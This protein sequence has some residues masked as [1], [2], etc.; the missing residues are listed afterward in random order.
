MILRF[1]I[2]HNHCTKCKTV[3]CNL[4]QNCGSSRGRSS[5]FHDG[6]IPWC[7]LG[8]WLFLRPRTSQTL[9]NHLLTT[10]GL[11]LRSLVTVQCLWYFIIGPMSLL[12]LQICLP[13]L[14]LHNFAIFNPCHNR[15]IMFC[16]YFLIEKFI[17]RPM[18]QGQVQLLYGKTNMRSE[19]S[20]EMNTKL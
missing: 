9:V 15:F 6:S 10:S 2:H 12:F 5:I 17:M 18:F 8:L 20:S 14:S 11:I 16:V 19:F 7:W 13:I 3:L 4:L 1:S